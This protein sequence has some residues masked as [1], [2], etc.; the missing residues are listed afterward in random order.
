MVDGLAPLTWP[1]DFRGA[2]L[3][4]VGFARRRFNNCEVA[5]VVV[6]PV[7][8]S[9]VLM[10]PKSRRLSCR[11]GLLGTLDSVV[12]RLS[13]GACEASI[14]PSVF[15]PKL[16]CGAVSVSARVEATVQVALFWRR[17]FLISPA[18]KVAGLTVAIS[19]GLLEKL[20]LFR[21]RYV[22]T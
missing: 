5:G 3:T 1:T 15:A 9:V 7:G 2:R 19:R 14:S 13:L 4:L 21:E 22:S 10:R 8:V 16:C 6:V 11:N 17:S 18:V 20:F 12:C